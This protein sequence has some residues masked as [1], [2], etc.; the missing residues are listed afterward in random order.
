M[1]SPRAAHTR[2]E[3]T[4]SVLSLTLVSQ[5][6]P[7][8]SSTPVPQLTDSSSVAVQD[9]PDDHGDLPV[10]N[11]PA[12]SSTPLP[13]FSGANA[14]PFPHVLN[15]DENSAQLTESRISGSNVEPNPPE[16]VTQT[17]PQDGE[18][19]D[20][21]TG[22]EDTPDS[23][24]SE[25]ERINS[26]MYLMGLSDIPASDIDDIASVEWGQAESPGEESVSLSSEPTSV[27]TFRSRGSEAPESGLGPSPTSDPNSGSGK[28]DVTGGE[29]RKDLFKD[30]DGIGQ[31]R[32]W[33]VKIQ[34]Q[35]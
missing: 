32:I 8:D 15:Q 30:S 10:S 23:T 35:K 26:G 17:E 5:V 25:I 18:L 22:D 1:T 12:G 13:Q 14:A 34:N 3:D 31:V 9:Y 33:V 27:I 16:N 28:S 19:T 11:T 2:D 21:W 20:V 6:L 24:R 29:R 7:D 4:D